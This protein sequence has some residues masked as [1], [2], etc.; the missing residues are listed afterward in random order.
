MKNICN[1]SWI[2]ERNN[3]NHAYFIWWSKRNA[4][5]SLSQF[6]SLYPKKFQAVIFGIKECGAC[7]LFDGTWML[8]KNGNNSI[9]CIHF[10][11][12]F[13]RHA[14]VLFYFISHFVG[15]ASLFFLLFFVQACA[16]TIVSKNKSN[17]ISNQ[18]ALHY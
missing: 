5:S 2:S 11:V 15:F 16:R 6:Y 8:A 12:D 7:Q 1:D 4:I 9:L 17:S 18:R 13:M 3:G 14:I 10:G